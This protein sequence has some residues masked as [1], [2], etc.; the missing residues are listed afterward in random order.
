M[1][2]QVVLHQTAFGEPEIEEVFEVWIS[3]QCDLARQQTLD[4]RTCGDRG[5]LIRL[6]AWRSSDVQRLAVA[7]VV[8]VYVSIRVVSRTAR[9]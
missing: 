7:A 8:V 6:A 5:D 4:L 1:A 9:S 2:D 3:K